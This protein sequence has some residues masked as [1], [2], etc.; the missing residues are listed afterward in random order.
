LHDPNIVRK[1]L[2]NRDSFSPL[3]SETYLDIAVA[4]WLLTGESSSKQTER[5]LG[6][7]SV[8]IERNQGDSWLSEFLRS[9]ASNQA[10]S[11]LRLAIRANHDSEPGDA[12]RYAH[13]ARDLFI[14]TRNK[15]GAA[16][17]EFEIVYA[18]HRGS[19]AERC[20]REIPN[21]QA[22]L[23]GQ[24]YH[25]LEIQLL[26]EFSSCRGMLTEFDAAWSLATKAINDAQKYNFPILGLRA[27]GFQASLNTV[28][29]RFRQ[30]WQGNS[31]GLG[32]FWAGSFPPDRGFQFYSDLELAAERSDEWNLAVIL[33]REVLVMLNESGRVNL[34][35]LAHFRL[36]GLLDSIGDTQGA[37]RELKSAGDLF[38]T[39]PPSDQKD[40]YENY[41][42]VM[43]ATILLRNGALDA[44]SDH[45]RRVSTNLRRWDNFNLHLRYLRAAAE[46]ARR[47]SDPAEEEIL[48]DLVKLG[49]SGFSRLHSPK[50]RWD[51]DREIGSGY[52]RLL[53]LGALQ[54]HKEQ[55]ALADWENYRFK[56]VS[57]A[58]PV[59]GSPLRNKV[60][61][62]LLS[63]RIG[64]LR[65]STVLTFAIL[66][67]SILAWVADDRGVR[68]VTLSVDPTT[69]RKEVQRFHL[70][71]SDRQSS[72]QKVNESGF[73]LYGWLLAPME[74]TLDPKR[75][76][77]IEA[78]E[79]LGLI[80]WAALVMKNGTY[81]GESHTLIN[82]PGIFFVRAS[83]KRQAVGNVLLAE[84]GA[85]VFEGVPYPPL[86]HATREVEGLVQMYP[87]STVLNGA[88]V[89]PGVLVRELP[90]ASIFQ[91]AGHA[92]DR[93]Y[94]GELLVHDGFGAGATL[95]ASAL[96]NMTLTR[97][98][99]IVLSGCSTALSEVNSSMS[100]H[101]LVSA[102][103]TA[104]AESV[105]ASN[106]DVDSSSTADL[107]VNFHEN[108][109]AG[110]SASVALTFAQHAEF[111][112]LNT[113]HP[114][115]WAAFT[116]FERVH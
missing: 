57:G 84:P 27:S 114:Y 12:E 47:T 81:F 62:A 82:T 105:V 96:S 78:D 52:R 95:S 74:R 87:G 49:N 31:L 50:D 53:E 101:G 60:S 43:L 85:V 10:K 69:L 33:Q 22:L 9:P 61:K 103:L 71:C 70:L 32:T 65:D 38:K 8:A 19:H 6:S 11:L 113:A 109:R 99:L 111:S 67:S 91:F 73:R 77:F 17:S 14:H 2:G 58:Y 18:L 76:L 59:S 3:E 21:L 51:W 42:E 112:N 55:Q 90:K 98:K 92:V 93:E 83:H 39:L 25:W 40:L 45:L 36:I 41:S 86:H 102:F 64:Q 72:I 13:H 4:N 23:T 115:F 110:N 48:T 29:G 37:K 56:A 116:T 80:P 30:S 89:T 106:W 46:I 28:E 24:N 7:L 104:G 44:A 1:E 88:D 75:T 107:M 34:A 68:E 100:P 108:F 66:P 26:L 15:A 20:V 79:F 16:R 35:A 63:S 54:P 5:A 97:T 94:G